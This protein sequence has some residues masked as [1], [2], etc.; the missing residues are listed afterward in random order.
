MF[1]FVH[2]LGHFLA[3]RAFDVTI[4]EFA[5]GFGP[6]IFSRVSKK[7]G[8]RYS[9]RALPFGGF[10]GM[11]GEDE[12]SD[13]PNAFS[14]KALWQRFIIIAAGSL[15]N[16]IIGVI[17]MVSL[18]IASK[19]LG[20]TVIYS[21]NPPEGATTAQSQSE[22]LMVGDKI[23]SVGGE[24]VHTANDLV[25]EIMRRG[26][27]DVDVVVLRDGKEVTIKN[28]TFPVYSA[29]GVLFGDIDFTVYAEGKTFPVVVKHA[30]YRCQFTIEMI[31][32][33]LF[34]LITGRYSVKSVSGPIGV[35]EAL[36]EAVESGIGNLLYITVILSMNLGIM[37]LLPLPALDGGRL[38]FLLIELVRGKPINPVYEGY[39]HLVGLIIL[40]GIM[41]AVAFK[42]IMALFGK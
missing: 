14:K 29:N 13:D 7:S 1:I 19:S 39:V 16:I 36:G 5:I 40:F 33:S 3:A 35:T 21:F 26:I 20:S 11:A 4:T 23:L 8:T 42:D 12:A 24:R 27:K 32:E 34:D 37:N 30:F 6:K 9:I 18:V 41:I 38:M 17:I 10:T 28:V 25:Y 22:G 15:T 2:E 31:W